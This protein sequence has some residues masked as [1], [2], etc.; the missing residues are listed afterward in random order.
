MGQCELMYTY[1]KAFAEYS[2]TWRPQNDLPT[3]ADVD[4][5]DLLSKLFT[6]PCK[7]ARWT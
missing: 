5:P 4:H 6:A 7:A 3:A 2:H 1:D